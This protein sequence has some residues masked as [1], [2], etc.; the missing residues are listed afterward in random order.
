MDE[1]ERGFVIKDKRSLDEEGDLKEEKE[2]Q[3]Y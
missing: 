3:H 1:E 2:L